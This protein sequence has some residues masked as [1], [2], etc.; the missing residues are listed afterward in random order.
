[1]EI[2]TV[3]TFEIGVRCIFHYQS[4]RGNG[5]NHN[6]FRRGPVV[7]I[8][9]EIVDN[10]RRDLMITVKLLEKGAAFPKG[11]LIAASTKQLTADPHAN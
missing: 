2:E 4:V 5:L 1:M 7:K 9:C 3:E 6:R 10:A 11:H 8:P